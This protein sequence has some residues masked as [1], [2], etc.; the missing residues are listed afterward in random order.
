M[1][2]RCFTRC[3]ACATF[4]AAALIGVSAGASAA[5]SSGGK[6][7][8]GVVIKVGGFILGSSFA[9]AQV[10]AQ[11]RF[12]AA[13]A[14]GKLKG[15]KIDYVGT[16]N[17]PGD[18][19][20][21]LSAQRQ[22]VE[23]NGVQVVV[24]DLGADT[25]AQFLTSQKVPWVGA[26][27][28]TSVCATSSSETMWGF[29]YDGCLVPSKPQIVPD[30][31]S[32]LYKYVST[33]LGVKHPTMT[34]ISADN[35]SG[36]NA[37]KGSASGAQGAGFTVVSAKGNVPTTVSDYSPYVSNWLTSAKGKQPQVITCLIAAQCIDVYNALKTGGF[38]G[39]YY[40]TLGDV[41]ALAKTFAGS[42]SSALYN[43]APSAAYTT[44]QNQ[45]EAF[46]PGTPLTSYSILPSY[47]A[48][49]MF[50]QAL[51]GLEK[52]GKPLTTTNI[53]QQLASQTW[54]IPGL[55]GPISYP[56]SSIVPTP[57]CSALV[58]YAADGSGAQVIA[59]YACSTKT[60]KVDPNL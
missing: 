38:T 53:R 3:I 46:A 58:Q 48:G 16:T 2:I 37:A 6:S 39:I 41:S 52:A 59:P 44:M 18:P 43:P 34:V 19:A 13:N 29:G 57:D 32:E 35:Q 24:P 47:F 30:G 60:Y 45:V 21:A 15:A 54:K 49:D 4:V 1:S 28:D 56:K 20:D 25:N 40:H 22:M 33:K 31:Y 8:K 27:Y 23:Q 10:G 9:G 42:L 26:G 50:V 7:Y 12:A 51:E 36:M 5:T 55:V 11:A 14:S 17:D